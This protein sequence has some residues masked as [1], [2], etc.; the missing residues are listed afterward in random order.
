MS[1]P[2]L[3]EG[4]RQERIRGMWK[5]MSSDSDPGKTQVVVNRNLKRRK[6]FDEN[7]REILP[8]IRDPLNSIKM[9]RR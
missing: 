5:N 9:G 1:G 7:M 6:W 4:R 2:S 3:G 8:G